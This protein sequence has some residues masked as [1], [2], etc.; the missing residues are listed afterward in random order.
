[1][2]CTHGDSKTWRL[3]GTVFLLVFDVN[4]GG[5]SNSGEEE[6]EDEENS[7]GVVVAVVEEDGGFGI[8]G[9]GIDADGDNVVDVGQ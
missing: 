2:A 5:L 9:G 1:M 6:E 4:P 3:G 7:V 8:D